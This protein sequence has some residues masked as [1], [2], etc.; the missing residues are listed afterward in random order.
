MRVQGQGAAAV[1]TEGR[2]RMKGH[3]FLGSA[4]C[5]HYLMGSRESPGGGLSD[6]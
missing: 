3:F 1:R 5:M 4:Y 6:A 2:T